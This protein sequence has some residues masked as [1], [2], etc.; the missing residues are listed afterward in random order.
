M[1]GYYRLQLA[2][3]VIQHVEKRLGLF[4]LDCLGLKFLL[5]GVELLSQD[6]DLA[7][8]FGSLILCGLE[9]Q[10]ARQLFGFILLSLSFLLSGDAKA[11][12]LVSASEALRVGVAVRVDW[13]G[14]V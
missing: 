9:L 5:A 6:C 4:Q 14:L 10:L 12:L 8:I 2:N 7:L 13:F 11:V 3:L 1:V